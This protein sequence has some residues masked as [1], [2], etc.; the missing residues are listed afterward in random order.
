MARSLEV[1]RA[2]EIERRGFA[3]R[4]NEEQSAQRARAAA[5]ESMIQEFR[6]NATKVFSAV[7]QN[8]SQM[9]NTAETLAGIAGR[10]DQQARSASTATEQ[11]SGNVRSV[12][13]A[14]E[15]LDAS[16]REISGQATQAKEVVSRAAAMTKSADEMV[17][18]LSTGADRIG[19]VI[20][21][22][23]TI[24]EQT[25]L[26]A[27]NATIEAARAGEAG[28]G[29][30]VVASEVKALATQTTKATEEIAAQIGAIQ[31]STADAVGAIRSIG[32]VMEDIST[33]TATIA[34]AVEEQSVS[35]QD[36]ARNVQQAATGANE[37]AGNM[38]TVTAAIDE[39]NRS[40]SAVLEVSQALSEQSGTM[41]R[42]IDSFLQKVSAA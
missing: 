2:A 33:F 35:T 25:N 20:K 11:T 36:I 37:L 9:Q 12:A 38:T 32:E 28:R 8:V 31:G 34:A 40:A 22:I 19:D 3:E 4:Q 5:I 18:Q 13:A 29:F 1:F 30:S 42:E 6:T 24:A 23:R 10:A 17:G 41:Q 7:A 39:T 16:I 27:L 26:L 14:A 15:E 21:L